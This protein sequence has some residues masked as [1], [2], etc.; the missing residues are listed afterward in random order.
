[1]LVGFRESC[2][3]LRLIHLRGV[4]NIFLCFRSELTTEVAVHGTIRLDSKI[5]S[6][7]VHFYESFWREQHLAATKLFFKVKNDHRSKFSNL[8][9]WKAGRSLKKIKASTGFEP[10]T[11]ANTGAMLYQLSYEATYWERGQFIEFISPVRS[12]MMRSIYEIIHIFCHLCYVVGVSSRAVRVFPSLSLRSVR[13][14][15]RTFSLMVFQ[16]NFARGRTGQM[17]KIY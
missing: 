14:S 16:G 7:N 13:L 5:R 4:K 10:V 1:M 9:N 6:Q 12:E 11:S 3:L 8:N 15:Y 2:E 17:R